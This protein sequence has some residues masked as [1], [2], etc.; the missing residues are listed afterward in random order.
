ME[1]SR[2]LAAFVALIAMALALVVLPGF[3]PGRPLAVIAAGCF[4]SGFLHLRL[5]RSAK[6]Q[7][8]L[9]VA[10]AMGLL[11]TLSTGSVLAETTEGAIMS[12]GLGRAFLKGL[13]FVLAGYLAGALAGASLRDS[14]R[15]RRSNP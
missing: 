8:A 10:V 6:R 5:A 3:W 2:V 7:D 4:A 11:L 14:R 1:A 9:V 15:L 13:T 12:T